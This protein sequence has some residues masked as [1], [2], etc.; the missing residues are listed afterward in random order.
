MILRRD[1]YNDRN[2]DIEDFKNDIAHEL[3]H[4]F[5]SRHP[6]V[7]VRN[8]GASTYLHNEIGGIMS[9]NI[10]NKTIPGVQFSTFDPTKVVTQKNTE[11]ILQSVI[12]VKD[13]VLNVTFSQQAKPQ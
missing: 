12:K 4:K 11:L 3:G 1:R 5:M 9:Y 6:D 7:K 2:R 13:K 8:P 10:I